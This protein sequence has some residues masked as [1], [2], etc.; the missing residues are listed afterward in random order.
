M[1]Y[2]SEKYDEAIQDFNIYISY[3]ENKKK[4]CIDYYVIRA[5]CYL[6]LKKNDEAMKNLDEF[7]LNTIN[8]YI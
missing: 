8:N 4:N 3:M 5:N 1:F 6:K 2:L 7:C